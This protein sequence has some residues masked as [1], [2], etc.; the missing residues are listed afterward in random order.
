MILYVGRGSHLSAELGDIIR[1]AHLIELAHIAELLGNGENVNRL[2][3]QIQSADGLIDGA[4]AWVIKTF[5][6]Q[7]FAHL[8]VSILF[9]HE[10]TEHGLFKVDCLRLHVGIIV[11][12]WAAWLQLAGTGI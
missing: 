4:V 7:D 3:L 8:V 12:E 2:F 11:G 10:R 1:S 6:P 5:R 9:N